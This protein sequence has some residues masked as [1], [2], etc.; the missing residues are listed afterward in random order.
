L[1]RELG[2]EMFD[3]DEVIA[4][5]E[6]RTIAEIFADSGEE[7]FRR[8]ETE[9]LI[10]LLRRSGGCVLATGGGIPAREE[11]RLAIRASGA[12]TVLLSAE[13]E[14]ILRRM[15]ADARNDQ[16]RPALTTLPPE[17]EIRAMLDRRRRYYEE[18]ADLTLA[19]DDKTPEELV[20]AILEVG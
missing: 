20:R 6:G 7:Y 2:L 18:L 13:P 12:L 11:N 9:V 4:S 19:T 16:T 3:T 10:R 14:T 1:S 17:E 15:A 5:E 8:K